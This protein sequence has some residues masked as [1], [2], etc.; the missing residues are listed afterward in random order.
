MFIFFL[1]LRDEQINITLDFDML[2]DNL[3]AL[4]SSLRR[5]KGVETKQKGIH[6]MLASFSEVVSQTSEFSKLRLNYREGREGGRKG[7]RAEGREGEGRER[8][9]EREGRKEGRMDDG[10]KKKK[11]IKHKKECLTMTRMTLDPYLASSETPV[12]E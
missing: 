8:E 7:G 5:L 12:K 1:I 10:K 4:L 11:E 9:R 2:R 6:G 3:L